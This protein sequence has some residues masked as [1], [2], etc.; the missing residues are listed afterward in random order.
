MVEDI[1]TDGRLKQVLPDVSYRWLLVRKQMWDTH[2]IQIRVTDGFRDYAQQWSLYLEGRK[3]DQNNQY[4]I[5]DPKKVVTHARG[6]ES[7]HNFGLALDS[8]FM[9]DDPYL[10]KLPRKDSDFLWSEYGKICKVHCLEWGGDWTGA[11]N[12][13]PH[14]EKTYGMSLHDAQIAY[15]DDGIR[16]V[17]EK[18]TQLMSCGRVTEI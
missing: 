13:R 8:A 3:K 10:A 11:K 17:F 9:G 12:D 14:C 7:F 6:G 16:G 5:V 1:V 18:C 15:E 2:Q 4:V